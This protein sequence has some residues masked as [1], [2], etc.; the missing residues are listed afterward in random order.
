ML[1]ELLND[2][3]ALAGL[4]CFVLACV[5]VAGWFTRECEDW[6]NDRRY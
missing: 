3:L 4:A 2:P 6:F 1:E 5:A